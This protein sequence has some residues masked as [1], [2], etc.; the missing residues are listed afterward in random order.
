MANKNTINYINER[1][2][3]GHI[4]AYAITILETI[5]KAIKLRATTENITKYI[6]TKIKEN[7]LSPYAITI[8]ATIKV[9]VKEEK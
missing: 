3:E 4:S 6:D 1:I 7:T 5:R 9:L 2:N 8:L